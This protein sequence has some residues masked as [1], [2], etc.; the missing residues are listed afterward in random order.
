MFSLNEPFLLI[1]RLHLTQICPCHWLTYRVVERPTDV[2]AVDGRH[3]SQVLPVLSLQV[4]KVLVPGSTVPGR[5]SFH[6]Y[7]WSHTH[8][9]Q[10]C[11]TVNLIFSQLSWTSCVVF[12]I[13][14]SSYVQANHIQILYTTCRHKGTCWWSSKRNWNQKQLKKTSN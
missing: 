6:I 14:K 1:S 8:S 10:R 3:E 5:G 7:N 11:D 12:V 9:C 4:I 2:G 13:N